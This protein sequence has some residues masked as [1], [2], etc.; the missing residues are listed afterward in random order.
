MTPLDEIQN[1]QD[2]I[3]KLQMQYR[4][5]T[6]EFSALALAWEC[7]RLAWYECNQDRDTARDKWE[8]VQHALSTYARFSH[9]PSSGDTAQEWATKIANELERLGYLADYHMDRA[10]MDQIV[11]IILRGPSADKLT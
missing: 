9:A 6:R 1:A 3:G 10:D 2:T 8:S 7:L 4:D 5:N 11:R